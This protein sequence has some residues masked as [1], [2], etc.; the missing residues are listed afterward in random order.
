MGVPCHNPAIILPLLPLPRLS[1][2][3]PS[4]YPT[5]RT[6]RVKIGRSNRLPLCAAQTSGRLSPKVSE[7]QCSHS[8]HTCMR[9]WPTDTPRGAEEGGVTEVGPVQRRRGRWWS[10]VVG[11][12]R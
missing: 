3:S 6:S 2:L 7:S 9:V 4:F 1:R 12:G 11:G 5:S 10:L 8:S